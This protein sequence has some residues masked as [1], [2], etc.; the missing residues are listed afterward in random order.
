MGRIFSQ[1]EKHPTLKSDASSLGRFGTFSRSNI[2]D[3]I[4]LLTTSPDQPSPLFNEEIGWHDYVL[5]SNYT[6]R[7]F[8]MSMDSDIAVAIM[9]FISEVV[10]HAGIGTTPLKLLYDTVLE[11]LD[12]SSGGPV[13][14]PKLR[15]KA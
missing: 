5:D 14:I 12:R 7:M 15:N 1:K 11:Y 10:W 3:H 13:L 8:G 2:G 9:R 4:E 6:A